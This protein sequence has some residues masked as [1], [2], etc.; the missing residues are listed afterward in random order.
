MPAKI[1]MIGKKFGLLTVI[2]KD[3]NRTTKQNIY[4][5]C[6]CDCG[7]QKSIRGTSLRAGEVKS[8]GCLQKKAATETGKNN[9]KNLLGQRFGKL[10][11]IARDGSK[12]HK[13]AE[14]AAQQHTIR[15][16]Q[17]KLKD[18]EE[19]RQAQVEKDIQALRK[20]IFDA[21][22]ERDALER[23]ANI[24]YKKALLDLDIE[25]EA[26]SAEAMKTVLEAIGPDLAAALNNENN[27]EIVAK[28]AESVAP[29]AVANGES[30]STAVTR[31]TRGTALEDV[32][33]KMM[34][35]Q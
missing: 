2:A 24:E 32:L 9:V 1:E 33:G 27:Q 22:Q 23:K 35:K 19:S 15:V 29:Y 3:E 8:C 17:Q 25:R 10:V 28:I 21:E 6:Q 5:I 11:V 12:N 7:N 4:W 14:T 16:A 31:L 34:A 26:K 13:A 30:V 20:A 18:E